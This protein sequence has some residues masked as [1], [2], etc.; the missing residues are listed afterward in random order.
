MGI[1]DG[2]LVKIYAP[3]VKRLLG[4]D[5]SPEQLNYVDQNVDGLDIQVE[6]AV[7]GD[8][9]KLEILAHPGSEGEVRG[10]GKD[11]IE[12]S[13]YE[14]WESAERYPIESEQFDLVMC[15]RVLQHVSNWKAAIAEQA[16]VLQPGG[17]LV[18]MLYNRFSPYGMKKLVDNLKDPKK[19]R[20]RNPIDIRRELRKNGLK[21]VHHSGAILSPLDL[22]PKNLSE[23]QEVF[24]RD[25][26]NLVRMYPFRFF[27]A[28]QII[29]ATKES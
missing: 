12:V 15:T 8:A 21:T 20:F 24:A 7:C 16:R 6:T 18:L 2:R 3:H 13:F 9:S 23:G 19:G 14:N 27:G 5:V 1:G 10:A 28:R 26:E 25:M 4:I 17:D 11:N 22:F 29:R